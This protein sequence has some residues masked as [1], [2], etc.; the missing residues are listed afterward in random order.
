MGFDPLSLGLM[1]AG[2]GLNYAAQRSAADAQEDA[3]EYQ[4]D[5]LR[6][7]ADNDT[8]ARVDNDRRQQDNADRYLSRIFVQQA[9]A[10]V[11]TDQGTAR[12]VLEDIES[13]VD[14]ELANFSQQAVSQIDRTRNAATM[15][16][17]QGQA[18]A[19]ATRLQAAGSLL[20]GLAQTAAAG[21]SQYREANPRETPGPRPYSLF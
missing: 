3:A 9:R 5:L 7:T 13:R 19:K 14:D 4:A 15:T 10:G 1:A 18:N 8:E 2:T 6:Q 17:W 20:G 11:V 12:L 21:Y 16:T